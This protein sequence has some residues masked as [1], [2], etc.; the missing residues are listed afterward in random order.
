[1]TDNSTEQFDDILLTC[2]DCGKDY[3]WEKGEQAF[4]F[5]KSLARPQRC[6]AC[7]KLRK[8][9]INRPFDVNADGDKDGNR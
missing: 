3:T 2:K 6:P 1:M 8:S 7:H 5:S 4:Y 9:T